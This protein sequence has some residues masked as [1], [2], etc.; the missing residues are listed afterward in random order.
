MRK[1]AVILV[2]IL[3]ALI[4]AAVIW[5]KWNFPTTSYRYRLTVAVEVDGQI[6][7]GSSVIEV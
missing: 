2:S 4:A 1:L 6:H 5:Y 7:S 3:V